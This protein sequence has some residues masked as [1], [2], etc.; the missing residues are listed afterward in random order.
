MKKHQDHSM[1]DVERYVGWVKEFGPTEALRM[2]KEVHKNKIKTNIRLHRFF[3]QD[4]LCTRC[5][6]VI[7]PGTRGHMH[8]VNEA[9]P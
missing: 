9:Q 1:E 6:Q 5:K 2:Q 8:E 3:F 4:G 7:E